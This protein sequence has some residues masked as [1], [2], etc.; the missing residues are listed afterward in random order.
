[1]NER[2]GFRIQRG[3]LPPEAYRARPSKR[4]MRADA[5]RALRTCA[6]QYR[7]GTTG[8]T[9]LEMSIDRAN[10]IGVDREIVE[11]ALGLLADEGSANGD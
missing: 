5:E 6:D 10:A 3:Q 2:G 8:R 9:N 1:M 7:K 4:S 11:Q